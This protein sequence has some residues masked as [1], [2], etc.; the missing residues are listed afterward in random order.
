[1]NHPFKNNVIRQR[2]RP[3][4]TRQFWMQIPMFFFNERKANPSAASVAASEGSKA[5]FLKG[6]GQ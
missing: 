4:G 6:V 1:M 3:C 2:K 5:R